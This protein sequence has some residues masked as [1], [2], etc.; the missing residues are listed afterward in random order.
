M[1]P[2]WSPLRRSWVLAHVVTDVIEDVELG[3]RCEERGVADTGGG[4]V[5]LGLVSH[6]AGV[7]AVDLPITRVVDVKDHDERQLVAECIHIRG[8]DIGN[9][10]KIG[11]VN[12][13]ESA[14][15]GTIEQLADAEEFF[16][17]RVGGNVE[18]L[19][20]SRQVGETDIKEFDVLFFDVLQYF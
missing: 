9:Q 11:L 16:V 1:H 6:L 3:L 2:R 13:L 4:E 10:L 15:R 8:G 14:D 17:N 7:A 20:H 12:L 19:L 5:L 18:V